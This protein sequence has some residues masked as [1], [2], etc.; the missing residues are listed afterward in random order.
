MKTSQLQIHLLGPVEILYQNQK[1]TIH[2][3]MERAILYYLAGEHQPVSRSTLIDLMWPNAENVDT[4]RALRTSLSRLRNEL[5]DPSILVTQLDQVW[6]EKSCCVVDFAQFEE[7]YR[8]LKNLLVIQH[9]R[10]PLPAQIVNQM[11]DALALWRGDRILEGDNLS[12]YPAMDSWRRE[13]NQKLSEQRKFLMRKLADHYRMVGKPQLALE[14]LTKLGRMDLMDVRLHLSILEIL[15]DLKRH[16]AVVDYCDALEIALEDEYNVP[17]PDEI[18]SRYQY[19]QIQVQTQS[20]QD[21]Q[22]WPVTPTMQLPLIGRQPELEQLQQAYFQGG[23]AV[24]SGELG[25]GKT[26]LVQELFQTLTPTPTLLYA[27]A[28][29]VENKLPFSAIVHCFRHHISKETWCDIDPVWANQMIRLLPEITNMR[30]DLEQPEYSKSLTERQNL[31]E[32]I[33]QV[34]EHQA[35]KYGRILF[36]LD[37]AQWVD[38]QTVQVLSYLITLGFFE[39]H[40]LLVIAKRTE[41]VNP[42]VEGMIN[43]VYRTYPVTKITLNGLCPNE[44]AMLSQQVLNAAPP[45]SLIE[46]LYR[47]TNG[48]PFFALEIIRHLMEQ[49]SSIKDQT[50]S[51]PLPESINALITARLNNLDE[52]SRNILLAAAVI[53]NNFSLDL[54]QSILNSDTMADIDTIDSLVKAGFLQP[55]DHEVHGQNRLQF[56]HTILRDVVLKGGSPVRVQ[57]YHH[58]V[59]ENMAKSPKAQNWAAITAEHFLKAGN[60]P[61]AFRWYLKTAEYAWTL[62]AKE[63]VLHAFE[64]AEQLYNT[65]TDPAID[66]EDLLNLYYQWGEF[67]YQAHHLDLLEEI[68]VKLQF[69]GEQ[70]DNQLFLGISQINLAN[71]CFL[72]FNMDTGMELIQKAI[73]HLELTGDRIIMIEALLHLGRFQWWHNQFNKTIETNE[74]VLEIAETLPL[75][76]PNLISHIFNARHGIAMSLHAKGE[77]ELTLQYAQKTFYDYFN[78]LN[79]FDRMRMY[80]MLSAANLIACHFDQSKAFIEQGLKISQQIDNDFTTE[81]LITTQVKCEVIQG[82]FDDAYQHA[83]EVLKISEKTNHTFTIINANSLVGD[84]FC[85]MQDYTNAIQY[86]RIAQIRAGYSDS[87]I[88]KI[89]NDLHLARALCLLGQIQ[90][91]RELIE[92]AKTLTI[93]ESI[94]QL[95]VKSLLI[96]GLCD[97]I[98]GDLDSSEGSHRAAMKLAEQKG[99]KYELI[100]SKVGLARVA[101]SKHQFESAERLIHQVLEESR[102]IHAVWPMLH[103][104]QLCSQ[105]HKAKKDSPIVEYQTLFQNLMS[106]MEENTQSDNLK[107]A[108][109]QARRL[110]AEGH[111]YP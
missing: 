7:H 16:Q 53:G 19:S 33:S 71:A 38:S 37:D 31:F 30:D 41:E 24:I 70:Y 105:L 87:S 80:H 62:S 111:H 49:P 101:L 98:D 22:K 50:T 58:L 99:L 44:L 91:A 12:S 56:I 100:W 35:E 14:L 17:L 104:L 48:N 46:Q 82:Q 26:R 72:R 10:H 88:Y 94:G 47:E 15:S 73:K 34:F 75:D 45:A 54:L 69:L 107:Q 28:L 81:V 4:R 6:L 103:G 9:P 55:A 64:Q 42:E 106:E 95:Y 11:Q 2:R 65:T 20:E 102:T 59:A 36:F 68:G 1:W 76:T 86:Y 25:S 92:N 39:T 43:R 27:P 93:K 61:E 57:T 66:L 90:E 96:S 79:A 110:W 108:F 21:P 18:L 109:S 78:R 3:R 89:R 63:D 77:S 84:I 29:E 32:A 67:A 83:K 74:K 13:L 8:S 51:L 40:G 97:I 60:I 5:P 85:I 52:R 23:L